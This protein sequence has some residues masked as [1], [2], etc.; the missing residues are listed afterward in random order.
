MS[1]RGGGGHTRG[2]G[3]V[4]ATKAVETGSGNTRQRQCL[5]TVAVE[6][7]TQWK[8]EAHAV[9]Y[10]GGRRQDLAV[11]AVEPGL[12]DGRDRPTKKHALQGLAGRRCAAAAHPSP[13]SA[14]SAVYGRAHARCLHGTGNPQTQNHASTTWSAARRVLLSATVAFFRWAIGDSR[15]SCSCRGHRCSCREHWCAAGRVG[16][17][18]CSCCGRGF[19]AAAGRRRALVGLGHLRQHVALCRNMLFGDTCSATRDRR[20]VF[21]GSCFRCLFNTKALEVAVESR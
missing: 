15:C 16:V 8:H 19:P 6:G 13:R 12:Q 14:H 11:P 4:L 20:H 5:T 3:G 10:R 21:G 1:H 2:T 17:L 9:S 7:N 18:T